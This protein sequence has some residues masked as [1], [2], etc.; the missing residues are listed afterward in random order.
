[1]LQIAL[2]NVSNGRL[3]PELWS[4]LGTENLVGSDSDFPW[5]G[6]CKTDNCSGCHG[7]INCLARLVVLD[8]PIRRGGSADDGKRPLGDGRYAYVP[9]VYQRRGSGRRYTSGSSLIRGRRI[10]PKCYIYIYIYIYI[11]KTQFLGG[12]K[13][14][15]FWIGF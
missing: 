7:K 11:R 14:R 13:K 12:R 10:A 5:R 2:V 1:M 9:E 4:C 8:T 6:P 15:G 3:E